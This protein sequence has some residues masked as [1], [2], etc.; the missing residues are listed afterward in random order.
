MVAGEA[1]GTSIL[2]PTGT[3]Y[4]LLTLVDNIDSKVLL[5]CS[6]NPLDCGWY[7]VVLIC[8]SL[9]LY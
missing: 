2:E 6:I 4:S 5:K 3:L 8:Q 7:G 9:E 1:A